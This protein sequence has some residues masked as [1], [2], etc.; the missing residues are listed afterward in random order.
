MTTGKKKGNTSKTRRSIRRKPD[1]TAAA[2]GAAH[3]KAPAI[4]LRALRVTITRDD[5]TESKFIAFEDADTHRFQMS[6]STGGW[7]PR[8]EQR[9]AIDRMDAWKALQALKEMGSNS[10]EASSFW[11]DDSL[12]AQVAQMAET[13]WRGSYERSKAAT[14]TPIVA[15]VAERQSDASPTGPQSMIVSIL[16][17][18]IPVGLSVEERIKAF[19]AYKQSVWDYAGGKPWRWQPT[20]P[21]PEGHRC[22]VLTL[23]GSEI[24]IP[25]KA[26]LDIPA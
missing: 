12:D 21:T 3:S 16:G 15:P 1:A 9:A 17:D 7:V 10:Q 24:V 20:A 26:C 8:E 18:G 23:S 11:A 4:R 6:S 22:D 2:S 13:M 25:G 14:A 5:G 19:E